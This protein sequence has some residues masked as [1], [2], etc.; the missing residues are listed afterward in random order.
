MKKTLVWFLILAMALTLFPATAGA[1]GTP[2]DGARD[3]AL[4]E[5]EMRQALYAA[6]DRRYSEDAPQEEEMCIRDRD[7]VVKAGFGVIYERLVFWQELH[8]CFPP[9]A[10]SWE[11]C[12]RYCL[13]ESWYSCR[14]LLLR[15]EAS[16]QWTSAAIWEMG[17]SLSRRSF[18]ACSMRSFRRRPEKDVY[19]RQG[20]VT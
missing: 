16:A 9:F 18:A 17:R 13:G 1:A 7:G 5:E 14:K 3:L 15:W 12:S 10:I 20:R 4:L 11:F 19:K 6:N 2:D 8:A